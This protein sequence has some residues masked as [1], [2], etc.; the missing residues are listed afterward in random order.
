M[1]NGVVDLAILA[2]SMVAVLLGVT[3]L[4]AG[5]VTALAPL[6]IGFLG[7]AYLKTDFERITEWVNSQSD[8]DTDPQ[9]EALTVLRR[10]YARGEID[11]DE[12]ERKVDDLLGTETVEQAEKYQAELIE[13]R[14]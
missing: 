12:F 9:E 1:V 2:V 10:R 13:E 7:F 6:L 3:M 5:E 11:Q 4:A 14:E 8:R